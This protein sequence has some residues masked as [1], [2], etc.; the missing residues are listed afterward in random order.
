MLHPCECPYIRIAAVIVSNENKYLN[1][2]HFRLKRSSSFKRYECSKVFFLLCSLHPF[3]REKTES[4]PFRLG[5]ASALCLQCKGRKEMQ[6]ENMAAVKPPK[7]LPKS[8][9]HWTNKAGKDLQDHTVQP[10]TK[11]HHSH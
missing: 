3:V 4:D 2:K 1:R 5:F 6:T 10:S 11:S 9:N 7:V 8:C